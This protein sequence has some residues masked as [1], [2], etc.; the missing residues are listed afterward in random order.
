LELLKITLLRWKPIHSLTPDYW[1]FIELS[2]SVSVFVCVASGVV[3]K[4]FLLLYLLNGVFQI[5]QVC[6]ASGKSLIS[7]WL[8]FALP[9]SAVTTCQVRKCTVFI[10]YVQCI[11]KHLETCMN[12]Q[13][14]L[15]I[16]DFIYSDGFT[17]TLWWISAYFFIGLNVVV[18]LPSKDIVGN[19][20]TSCFFVCLMINLRHDSVHT[21]RQLLDFS[22]CAYLSSCL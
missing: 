3:S 20:V 18:H 22:Y 14:L 5:M 7:V 12:V 4:Y 8:N 2:H 10:E 17:H 6:N 21:F 19:D 1:M 9:R 15:A 16:N 11:F 13:D